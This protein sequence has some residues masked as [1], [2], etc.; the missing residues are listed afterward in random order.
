MSATVASNTRRPRGPV[1]NAL[2][3]AQLPRFVELYTLLGALAVAAAVLAM[4]G[5]SIAGW[6]VL[7]ALIYLVGIGILST[8]VENRRKATDR[9]IRGLVTIAFLLALI[10]LVSTLI[11]VV[12]GG[13]PA[14][15]W[16]FITK[17]GGSVFDPKTLKVTVVQG[18]WQA[19]V[20]TLI[21]TGIAAVISIP[22]G[23]MA[24]IYLVEYAQPK[25]W[26]AR[27]V[28]FLVDVMTGIPSIVAGLF[29]F[30][31]FTLIVGPKAFSGF[32]ASIALSV[33]MIPIVIRSSEEML[34]LVPHDLREASFA[35]GVTK[36]S[37]I[38]RIVLPTAIA[39]IITGVMLAISRVIGETAPIF[40]AA[41]FTDNFNANPF[42][43]AM[44]TLPVMAYSG[45]KFP[46]QD[47]Q[48]SYQSAWGA[49]L[50]LVILVVVLNLI[51][52]IVA[53]VFAP[54]G[55]R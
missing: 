19:I 14:M 55:L 21:I 31:L 46:S 50:L 11:T 39:G 16:D 48:A 24:A 47:I 33:L 45:Y 7:S 6:L 1:P 12:V 44:Q 22:I 25:Q 54:K 40:I 49:A 36:F 38:V 28:T 53:R 37:T 2:T 34:K 51:A 4:I 9:V 30:S 23:I 20:G 5:F 13:A 43:G 42:D 17:T 15:T 3:S 35:L 29:A 8:V 18:A 52:R 10:P 32:S 26:M 41:S 27:T